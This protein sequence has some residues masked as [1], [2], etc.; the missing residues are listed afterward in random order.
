M[1]SNI[2]TAS[3]VV[4]FQE[5]GAD[6]GQLPFRAEVDSRED[7]YNA[8]KTSFRPGDDVFIL[9]YHDPSILVTHAIA[10]QG[11]L[12]KEGSETITGV[13]EIITFA[14]QDSASVSGPIVGVPAITWYGANLGGLRVGDDASTLYVEDAGSAG[15]PD[16][17]VGAAKV[18]YDTYVT[19][20]KLVN[21]LIVDTPEYS[22]TNFFIGTTP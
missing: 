16:P 8:G 10:T 11:F 15:F 9:L 19:V 3:L 22:I 4:G 14:N 13:E 20:Y 7:G 12:T 17:Y 18:T 2:V 6:A 21:T 5:Q 1:P